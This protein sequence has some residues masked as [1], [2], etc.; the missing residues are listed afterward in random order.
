MHAAP[1]ELNRPPRDCQAEADTAAGAIA[2]GLYAIERIEEP[3]QAR[4]GGT[5]AMIPDRDH[6]F[7]FLRACGE[8]DLGVRGSIANRVP[9]NVLERTVEQVRVALD[10]HSLS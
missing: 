2:V 5:R 3:G 6:C 4:F 1:M 7:A 8:V 10:L 9:H